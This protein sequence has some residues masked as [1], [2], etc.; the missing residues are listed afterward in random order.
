M[1]CIAIKLDE[2]T[3][4][5]R[6][7]ETQGELRKFYLLAT[8]RLPV[9]NPDELLLKFFTYLTSMLYHSRLGYYLR[10]KA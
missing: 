10:V 4:F 5:K 6:W 3:S 1:V 2:I 7:Y 9:I 8:L